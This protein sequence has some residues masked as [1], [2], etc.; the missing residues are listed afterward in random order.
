MDISYN[1]KLVPDE[2]QNEHTLA[3][4]N[5]SSWRLHHV[6]TSRIVS[7]LWLES[8]SFHWHIELYKH[9][10]NVSSG[11]K[12]YKLQLSSS[13]LKVNIRHQILLY[14]ETY[15]LLSIW[16]I[17]IQINTIYVFGT[18]MMISNI[19]RNYSTSIKTQRILRC[20]INHIVFQSSNITLK[21]GTQHP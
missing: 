4:Q 1:E 18:N 6:F 8:T 12:K 14:I 11:V 5:V 7:L 9:I 19:L 3:D 17:K 20:V 13:F 2:V 16:M 15:R 10:W 21:F